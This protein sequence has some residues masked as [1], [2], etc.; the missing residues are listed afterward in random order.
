MKKISRKPIT[1]IVFIAIAIILFN[2]SC[3]KENTIYKQEDVKYILFEKDKY[4]GSYI[5]SD[6][7]SIKRFKPAIGWNMNLPTSIDL[8]LPVGRDQRNIGS[9]VSFAVTSQAS[10]YIQQKLGG[11]YDENLLLSPSYLHSIIRL[12]PGEPDC[13]SDTEE[14][15][16][17]SFFKDAYKEMKDNGCVLLKDKRYSITECLT[18]PTASLRL[19]AQKRKIGSHWKIGIEDIKTVLASNNPVVAGIKLSTGVGSFRYPQKYGESDFLWLNNIG[20]RNDNKDNHAVVISGYRLID[21]EL[22]YQIVNSWGES[23]YRYVSERVLLEALLKDNNDYALFV[24]D[25]IIIKE[26]NDTFIPEQK[27]EA[28]ISL[29]GNMNFNKIRKGEQETRTLIVSNTGNGTLKVSSITLPKGFSARPT[30]FTVYPNESQEIQVSFLANNE[31][32]YSGYVIVNSNATKGRDRIEISAEVEK[33]QQI[34]SMPRVNPEIGTYTS[35]IYQANRC[36]FYKS[37][38]SLVVGRV[39]SYDYKENKVVFSIK[40]TDGTSFGRNAEVFV[41]DDLCSSHP[42]V[43]ANAAG[44]REVEMSVKLGAKSTN[45]IFYLTVTSIDRNG[46]KHSYYTAPITIRF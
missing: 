29:N 15:L 1:F 26:N 22:R 43:R 41:K 25:D 3:I 5:N 30:S 20:I 11:V 31:G 12:K 6:F 46:E 32:F 38:L 8:Y 28:K 9:C 33:E 16:C 13:S 24:I 45:Y 39:R 23:G 14:H 2:N 44:K 19:E 18:P 42:I 7:S 36:N 34:I 4:K 40:K 17:G 27:K 35:E 10:F 21:G 37:K